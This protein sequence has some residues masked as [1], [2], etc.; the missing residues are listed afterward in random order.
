MEDGIIDYLI[1]NLNLEKPTFLEIGVG[2]YA[3]SNTRFLF[4]RYN[5][6]GAIVDKINNFQKKYQTYQTLE[7]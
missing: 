3:E 6:K 4:E 1:Y 5:S 2:D 7:R